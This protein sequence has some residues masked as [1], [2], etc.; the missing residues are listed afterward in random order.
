MYEEG[1]REEGVYKQGGYEEAG[2]EEEGYEKSRN[3]QGEFKGKEE[4]VETQ[5]KGEVGEE[6]GGEGEEIKADP[7]DYEKFEGGSRKKRSL[8]KN[9]IKISELKK[10][11]NR[12]QDLNMKN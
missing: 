9:K 8:K 11:E 7:D 4:N 6:K 2:F 10:L 12:E 3:G 5:H 1:E